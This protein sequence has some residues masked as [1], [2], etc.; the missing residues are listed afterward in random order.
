MYRIVNNFPRLINN[1]KI[2]YIFVGPGLRH[3]EAKKTGMNLITM[4]V[5]GR[6][7]KDCVMK[8]CVVVP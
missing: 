2:N 6:K 8:G 1:R 5:E 7:D 3:L 4:N